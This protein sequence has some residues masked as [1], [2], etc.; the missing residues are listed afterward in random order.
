MPE[1][2]Y[3]LTTARASQAWD[4]LAQCVDALTAAWGRGAGPPD[5]ATFVPADPPEL[6]RLVLIELIK[7]DLDFRW[8]RAAADRKLLEAY[9]AEFSELDD[10]GV[11]SDL[12]FEEFHV[13][14]RCA[15]D[16]D[17]QEY[18]RRFP[19]QVEELRRLFS[20]DTAIAASTRAGR[21][22][23]PNIDVGD[24]V[25]DFDLLASLGEGAF[26][27][28]FL[29]RQ[30]SMQRLV[31]LKVSA[32]HGEEP[33]TLA[34]LDHPHIVRVYD[35]RQIAERDL[36]M[37]YMQ[38]IAGGTLQSVVRMRRSRRE[39][40][41][42]GRDLLLIVDESLDHRGQMPPVESPSRAWLATAPWWQMVAWMG[43]RLAKALDYAHGRD[44]LHRDV[45][46]ANVLLD[47]DAQ[48][49][50][51]D[52]NIS[53]CSK[54]EGASPAAFFGGSLPYMSPEQLEACSPKYN[55]TPD[56]IDARSD[57][58]SLGVVLWELLTG[59][60][61]YGEEAIRGDWSDTLV[62]ILRRRRNQVDVRETAH[63]LEPAAKPLVNVLL[64]CLAP[65][66]DDRPQSGAEVARRLQL[67]LMPDVQA[68]LAIQ[69]H[70]WRS[71]ALKHPNIWVV[72][73]GLVP[74]ML[75][76]RFNYL[77]NQ[78]AIV[79]ALDENSRDVFQDVS[80]II[81][82]IAFPLGGILGVLLLWRLARWLKQRAAIPAA[83]RGCARRFALRLGFYV[84]LLGTTEWLTAGP[85]FPLGFHL[86]GGFVPA[87]GWIHFFF[88]MAICG[89]IAASYPYLLIT[90][91]G[92]RVYFP[93]L[94]ESDAPDES[95]RKSLQLVG[96]VSHVFL[97][98]SA[99]V[100]LLGV[101]L[102]STMSATAQTAAG[103]Q[104][105]ILSTLSLV[106]VLGFLLAFW[107]YRQIHRDLALLDR[108]S[109]L[110]PSS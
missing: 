103:G 83:E 34:Q 37:M 49:K 65:H 27:K 29:A 53:F 52:F 9:I 89:L 98:T 91:L 75:A 50:L 10:D 94:L 18:I 33:Q 2:T 56:Q 69:P 19:D 87:E 86:M 82:C 4:L 13:R 81:N 68:L 5:L 28:V 100:P 23:V 62:E 63:M 24:A 16:V 45:K 22:G 95:D 70:T 93:A 67:C 106:G 38:F 107:L 105:V 101:L 58:Y 109:E 99:A 55:R 84:A 12:I 102:I 32:D 15:D 59:R 44:V 72:V 41:L 79:Q 48:P 74:N 88:S 96:K 21:R 71:S 77:Y 47:A 30:K 26:G 54:L 39:E 14:R 57:L 43:V 60:L 6:R 36:R 20:L 11:P 61:P 64:A 40:P 42:T 31:A 25:D 110:Q 90:L 17:P 76:G 108:A 92:T 46:P 80:W 1:P 85:I 3:H 78:E 51:A 66:A 7:V 73:A 8:Q 35:Q 104:Q 97:A